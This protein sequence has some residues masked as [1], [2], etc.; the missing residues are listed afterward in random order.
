[1]ATETL[2]SGGA[3]KVANRVAALAASFMRVASVEPT[4]RAGFGHPRGTIRLRTARKEL[5]EARVWH[6]SAATLAPMSRMKSRVNP[7]T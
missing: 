4:A 3:G 5:Q 6:L 7:S 2:V 1:M